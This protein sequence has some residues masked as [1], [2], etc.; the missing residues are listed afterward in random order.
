MARSDAPPA[1]VATEHDM[2]AE[3]LQYILYGLHRGLRLRAGGPGLHRS[4]T[5]PPASST[6]RR[7]S[8][9]CSAALLF[10]TFQS[11]AHLPLAAALLL[12]VLAVAPVGLLM[13]RLAIRPLR[14]APVVTLIIVTVGV[15][16]ILRGA[17]KLDL[18]AGRLPRA[19]LLRASNP[20]SWAAPPSSLQYLWVVGLAVGRPGGG[21][22]SSST[23]PSRARR[24][25]PAR[26]TPRPARLAGISVERMVQLS[27]ALSAGVSALAGAVI[28]PITFAAL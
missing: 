19:G 26:S 24:C 14:N 15:S 10:Y 1:C 27:F 17:A 12:A 28:S 18:G 11:L 6:S 23:A 4:S 2:S 8:S 16:V 21:S 5:T 20:S 25:R 13:E 3:L 22:A 7:A 9:S